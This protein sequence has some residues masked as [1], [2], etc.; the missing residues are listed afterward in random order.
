M[1]LLALGNAPLPLELRPSWA[2][3]SRANMAHHVTTEVEVV[4]LGY[5]RQRGRLDF[6][7]RRTIAGLNGQQVSW[8]D[9]RTCSTA[10]TAI[11]SMQDIPTPKF[12]PIGSSKGPPVILD[13]IGYSL[14]SY[15][16]EGTLT[17]DTNEGT[18]LATWI[19]ATLRS[20]DSCWTSSVPQ[21]TK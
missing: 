13:G 21:R 16:D 19:E 17:A 15:S 5:D 7:L 20:L 12:A 11:A 2:E 10:R 14:H 8:A 3:F 6:W 9:T 4:T 18:P 1:L